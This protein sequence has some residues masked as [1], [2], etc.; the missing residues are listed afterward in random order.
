M[1][2]YGIHAS[3]AVGEEGF[4]GRLRASVGEIA[5]EGIAGAHGEKTKLDAVG[6]PFAREDAIDDFVR[7]AVAA[8][9]EE[10]AVALVVGFTG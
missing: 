5:Q 7:G 6:L 9:G 3:L 1:P 2:L 8:D 10:A 4:D